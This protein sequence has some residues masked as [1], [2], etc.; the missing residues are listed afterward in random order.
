MNF[1]AFLQQADAYEDEDDLFSRHAR[2]W[3]ELSLTH[4]IAVRRV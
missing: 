1:D 3:S 4:P 2:F